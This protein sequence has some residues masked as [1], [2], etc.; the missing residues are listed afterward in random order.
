MKAVFCSV[1]IALSVAGCANKSVNDISIAD[2][3]QAYKVMFGTVLAQRA[4]NVRT[5]AQAA[6]SGGALLGAGTGA[7]LGRNNGAALAGLLIGGLAGAAIHNA[8]E[9]SNGIEYTIAFADGSTQLIAQVQAPTDPVFEAGE[10]VM[11][12]FGATTNRVLS[13]AHLPNNVTRPKQVRVEGAGPPPAKLGVTSCQKALVG[14]SVRK[15]C[16]SQ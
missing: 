9:T 4:V 1:L 8:A 12:Q 5:S 7:A 2:A 13:A 11:V 15:S 3:G 6:T 16:T 14:G 10:P